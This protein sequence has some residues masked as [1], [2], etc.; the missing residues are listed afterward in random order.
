MRFCREPVPGR[1]RD[2]RPRYGRPTTGTEEI[3]A[4]RQLEQ[5]QRVAPAPQPRADQ[6]APRQ[7]S[8]PWPNAPAPPWL[9][10]RAATRST[11][12]SPKRPSTSSGKTQAAA[13]K[14]IPACRPKRHRRRHHVQPRELPQGRRSAHL[15]PRRDDQPPEGRR[16][17]HRR[18]R[19]GNNLMTRAA[20]ASTTGWRPVGPGGTK[21]QGPAA[22]IDAL[23]RW[24]AP[25]RRQRR[26]LRLARSAAVSRQ[27]AALP[28]PARLVRM[29]P[30]PCAQRSMTGIE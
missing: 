6:P 29:W 12:P 26:P 20:T 18:R 14:T 13:W 4:E 3:N 10:C 2:R 22:R 23:S 15:I 25:P 11:C 16:E 9:R 7:H 30:S 27:A 5:R 21:S 19:Q 17:P 28:E 24:V 8:A 1:E